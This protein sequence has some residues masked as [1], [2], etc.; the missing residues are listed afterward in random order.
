MM[1]CVNCRKRSNEVLFDNIVAIR[2]ANKV[3]RPI[4]CDFVQGNIPRGRYA[5]VFLVDYVYS[6]VCLR[7]LFKNFPRIIRRAIVYGKNGEI[8][9]S[10]RE[11]GVKALS[12]VS[13]SVVHREDNGYFCSSLLFRKWLGGGYILKHI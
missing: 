7:I 8:L 9:V 4:F 3:E 2:K 1:L 5:A 6:R 13:G 11:K 10:L 12:E